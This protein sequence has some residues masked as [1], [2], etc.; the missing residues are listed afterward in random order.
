MADIS[1]INSDDHY[2][3]DMISGIASEN[4][5]FLDVLRRAVEQRH[6][7]VQKI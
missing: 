7:T 6:I 1:V 3:R 5:L 4:L 2:A